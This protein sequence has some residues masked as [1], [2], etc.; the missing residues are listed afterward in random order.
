[1]CYRVKQSDIV[2]EYV[3]YYNAPVTDEVTDGLPYYHANGFEHPVLAIITQRDQQRNLERMQW[4][5]MPN[6]KKPIEDMVKMSN[7]TLNAKSETIYDLVSFKG[8]IVNKRC[9]LPVEGFY[10]YKEVNKDKLP[11]FIHPKAHPYFN[12]ACIYSFYQNPLNKEWVKS[13]SIVT[14]EANE[15]MASIHNTKKRMPLIIDNENIDNWL[16]PNINKEEINH[17]MTPCNDS[18]MAAYRVSRDLIKIGND[19]KAFAPVPEETLF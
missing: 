7:N 18:T 12:L 1:M 14:G 11:Y 16:N 3:N 8:S 4:G 13:F 10:E 17:M 2:D 15:L 6:W 19:P 9:I 5:L